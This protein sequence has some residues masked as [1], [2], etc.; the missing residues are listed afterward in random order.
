MRDQ[1]IQDLAPSFFRRDTF[2]Q[3]RVD[4]SFLNKVIPFVLDNEAVYYSDAAN[5]LLFLNVVKTGVPCMTPEALYL[6][7]KGYAALR[8][9]IAENS[10]SFDAAVW[11]I[12]GFIAS[13][14]FLDQHERVAVHLKALQDLV[15]MYGGYK[16]LGFNGFL[17]R[18]LTSFVDYCAASQQA[19]QES[20]RIDWQ[21]FSDENPGNLL[22][23]SSSAIPTGFLP[24]IT[25]GLLSTRA[26]IILD[27][28]STWISQYERCHFCSSMGK[29]RH[30]HIARCKL[31]L[32]GASYSYQHDTLLGLALLAYCAYL[33]NEID[34]C[35]AANNYLQL[36]CRSI[37]NV[38]FRGCETTLLAWVARLLM[39][40]YGP[41]RMSSAFSD[42]LMAAAQMRSSVW[43]QVLPAVEDSKRFF[44]S[45]ALAQRLMGD[46]WLPQGIQDLG[47]PCSGVGLGWD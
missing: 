46:D 36:Y 3:K 33:G 29:D 32:Q 5:C 12:L 28:A 14:C 41:C 35:F 7:G 1:V 39:A 22:V 20:M 21:T 6:L 15:K 47:T 43:G 40:V 9:G 25:K 8:R 17:A 13:D 38:S 26:I 19:M 10:I 2:Q 34:T 42:R 45:D 16:L 11:A 18:A 27:K 23:E 30:L 4:N 31:L 44:W 37:M 24:L